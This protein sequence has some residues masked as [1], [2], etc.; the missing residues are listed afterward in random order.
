MNDHSKAGAFGRSGSAG[1]RPVA[2][3]HDISVDATAKSNTVSASRL[4]VSAGTL[5]P[6]TRLRTVAILT[7]SPPRAGR[8]R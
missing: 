5:E 3:A 8:R 1:R 7:T 6:A 2:Y 4:D